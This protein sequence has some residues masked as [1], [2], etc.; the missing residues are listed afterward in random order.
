MD[1]EVNKDLIKQVAQN[2]CLSLSE[3]EITGFEQDFKD[4]LS[5]FEKLAAADVAD[6]PS[7]HP[8]PV[9]NKYRED[10]VGEVLTHKEAMKNVE[11]KSDGFIRGPKVV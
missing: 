6:K 1:I 3:E 5:N 9:K 2:A 11:S 8:V 7:F 4:I 10:V